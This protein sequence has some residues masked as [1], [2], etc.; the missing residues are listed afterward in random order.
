MTVNSMSKSTNYN[1]SISK[2]QQ[3][4]KQSQISH[5]TVANLSDHKH[6]A[7]IKDGN[8]LS[9]SISQT[10]VP[11]S[12]FNP[13]MKV[14]SP[15]K[16]SIPTLFKPLCKS[17]S[18]THVF[19]RNY[20]VS[21]EPHE[22]FTPKLL[23][24]SSSSSS[25]LKTPSD[26][27]Y[28]TINNWTLNNAKNRNDNI[29]SD[30]NVINNKR[31]NNGQMGN[32]MQTTVA[33]P[34]QNTNTHQNQQNQQHNR[35]IRNSE[36]MKVQNEKLFH[37]PILATIAMQSPSSNQPTNLDGLTIK[38]NLPQF[39]KPTMI[40]PTF[41]SKSSVQLPIHG[42][43]SMTSSS[44]NSFVGASGVS[45]YRNTNNNR[46][47][48]VITFISVPLSLSRSVYVHLFSVNGNI[49]F[50]Y[51]RRA[52]QSI[53]YCYSNRQTENYHNFVLTADLCIGKKS[54]YFFVL[55]LLLL[56]LRPIRFVSIFLSRLSLFLFQSQ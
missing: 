47:Y 10:S 43:L 37:D 16:A 6:F 46:R 11:S 28:N 53:K 17:T 4:Q 54:L 23:V 14:K 38:Q 2:I 50:I 35:I 48:V 55:L 41:K 30:S 5:Q 45:G 49:H 15:R 31:P 24:K 27:Y 19:N 44:G 7:T 9:K 42:N 3:Q 21:D 52:N 18:N 29:T 20:D 34:I 40:Y 13:V 22:T 12:M 8:Q 26:N 33:Q 36:M 51:A 25:I 1:N 56:L 32:Y 39:C